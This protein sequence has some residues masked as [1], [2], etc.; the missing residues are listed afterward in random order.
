MLGNDMLPSA[1]NVDPNAVTLTAVG[2]RDGAHVVGLSVSMEATA[3]GVYVGGWF[4]MTG[5]CVDGAAVGVEVECSG[6]EGLIVGAK[7]GP[8]VGLPVGCFGTVGR[9]VGGCAVGQCVG[10]QVGV[11]VGERVG[12][13]EGFCVGELVNMC[14]GDAVGGPAVGL[15]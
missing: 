12:D 2:E 11:R 3:V 4:A 14:K 5:G 1:S 6:L 10:M 13:A 7:D 8:A 9:S 15:G